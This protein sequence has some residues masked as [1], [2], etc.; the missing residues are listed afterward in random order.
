MTRASIVADLFLGL[1]ILAL[2]FW[3]RIPY[4]PLV[5]GASVLIIYHVSFSDLRTFGFVKPESIL[6][7]MTI[8]LLM[9]L[10]IVLISFFMLIPAL[11]FIT[12][13][14]HQIGV[15]RQIEGNLKVLM[16]SIGIGSL[17]GGFT[18]EIIFRGFFMSRISDYIPGNIGKIIS[19]VSTSI[20]F[21]YLHEYQGITGQIAIAI[22]GAI[23]GGIY[24][25]NKGRLWLN[26]LVHGFV[27][28]ISMT[29]VYFGIL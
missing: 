10:V 2:L 24:I 5:I 19:V 28:T 6:T 23:L 3:V 17:I 16:F 9:A 20:F 4:M 11:E 13:Q 1:F 12:G 22:M 29:M 25:M 8:A 21:G 7:T 27:N 14:P 18:E 26:I 15:F